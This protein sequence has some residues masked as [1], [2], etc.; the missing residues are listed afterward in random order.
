MNNIKYL[1]TLAFCFCFV[2]LSAQKRVT[3]HVWN[4]S[5]G[6]VVMATVVELDASNRVVSQTRTDAS[7]NF[8]LMVKYPDKSKL[9]V[10]YIGYVTERRELKGATSFRIEMRD[11][12][13]LNVAEVQATRKT[14]SNGLVIPEHEVSIAKQTLDM[15]AMEGLSFET[16]GEALQGQIAGLDII[17]NSGNLGAGTSMRLRGVSSINGSA[18]PL[19][20]V[21]GH[22]LED[23]DSDQL[24]LTN[25]EDE[26]QFA[27]LLQINP[28]DIKSIQV[29]KDAAATAIWGAR[30]TNGVIEITTRRGS[31][32]KTRLDFSYKF[33]GKWMPEGRKMLNGD[34]Y[35]MMLKEAYFNPQQSDEAA[36]IVELMYRKN[37]HPNYYY[38]FNKNTD[39]EK[40]VTQFG[41]TH[42][43]GMTINGGGEKATF[44]IS[45]NYDYETGHIIEQKLNRITT[46]MALDYWVSDRIKFSSTFS[47][48]YTKNHGNYG[49]ILNMAYRAMP[50]MSVFRYEFN[51]ETQ[52]AFNTGE[53]FI[54]PEAAS[55]RGLLDNSSGKTSYYL[56]DMVSNGNPVA[57]AKFA[58]REQST[59]TITPNLQLEYK[60]L[61]K[62][63]NETQLNYT[64]EV[65]LN[66]YTNSND[67]Y[68]PQSL[69]SSKWNAGSGV[70]I[71][72]NS[73]YKSL[74]FETKHSIV[75]R[76]QFANKK[77][78][79]QVLMSGEMSST[80]STGQSYTS[81]GV[82]GGITSPTAPGYLR[83]PSTSTGKSHTMAGTGSFHYSYGGKYSLT[84]TL[85]ADGSTKFGSGSKWG[86]FPG[87]AGRWNVSDEGFFQSLKPTINLFAIRA[88]WGITG[89]ESAISQNSQYNTYS[90]NGSYNGVL[91]MTP[92]ALRLTTIKWEKT[93]SW[94]LGFNL[95][96]FEFD[97]LQFDLN[98]YKR[99]TTDLL[100]S[101]VSIPSYTGFKTLSAANVGAVNNEGW[102]LYVNT[103]RL[104]KT[105][106]FYM[107]FRFNI[108]QTINTITDMDAT[109]LAS[110]N[111]PFNYENLSVMNRVQIGNALG[112]IYG[113][114]HK[115][116]Y[117]YDYEHNGY[118]LDKNGTY[119]TTKND[120]FDANLDENGNPVRNTARVNKTGR[121][122]STPIARD[123]QG[124][125][126]YDK[127]G[128][129]LPMYFNYGGA[130]YQ[131]RGGDV[132]YEDINHD[133][134][135]NDLDIVYL[136]SSNPKVNGGF[137]VDFTYGQWQLK[138]NFNFRIG[139]KI[140]NYARLE[141]ESM[142][143]NTNQAASVNHRWRKNGQETEIPRALSTKVDGG[144][145]YNAL[146]NS[147]YV[148][149][150]DFLRFQYIQLSYNVPAKVLKRYGFRSLRLSL[151]GNNLY[152]WTKYS[153]VDPEI[154]ADRSKGNAS[155]TTDRNS[156][157]RNRSFTFSMNFGF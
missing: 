110:F 8:S 78:S 116:V 102:D 11:R 96:L 105:G 66:A 44:R 143:T 101:N 117:A 94:N 80:T 114:I 129:P 43:F 2:A 6:P 32:G 126:I 154:G 4:K 17:A 120:Y 107:N 13:T 16:A 42:N 35:T 130:N 103:G 46:R 45:A 152:F 72:A 33:S 88:S 55:A 141:A 15:D 156:T 106:K 74:K 132:I 115:G 61:G 20:V 93:T 52:E 19:I 18:E 144:V 68:Y 28:E 23:Y 57:D 40:E 99:R 138:T 147:R 47:L 85:R 151:S 119:N 139:N 56:S 64:G 91:A 75:F 142:R 125:V 98:I 26:M 124:N 70:N 39:W 36:G 49:S 140:I 3:G 148:E 81:T 51:N 76:P 65:Y 34:D 60:F 54:L 109:V 118:F 136:G 123:A 5:D 69:T 24:D 145:S 37:S 9:Q 157:P 7:G 21:D 59:Y 30:G 153:G 1:L 104:F 89:N 79:L 97:L 131:F 100:N 83:S 90:K 128:N 41:Q 48:T 14:R 86:F 133:G 77:H 92:D 137:G 84:F 53:Y 135:I 10:S 113:F 73:E 12:K 87:V 31:R 121:E 82:N 62:E 155:P 122:L 127:D 22:I 67:S 149:P 146:I 50:N 112:G 38:N 25:S 134:Q 108:A 29:L 95:N 63:D 150:G 71:T 27:N 111:Q 58:W